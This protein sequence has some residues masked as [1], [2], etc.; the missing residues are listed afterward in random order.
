MA[1]DSSGSKTSRLRSFLGI[2]S[3]SSKSQSTSTSHVS[4]PVDEKPLERAEGSQH[5]HSSD[6]SGLVGVSGG[7]SSTTDA[8]DQTGPQS[9]VT[10]AEHETAASRNAEARL[11]EPALNKVASDDEAVRSEPDSSDLASSDRATPKGPDGK[12]IWSSAYREAVG[13]LDED[14]RKMILEGGRVDQLFKALSDSDAESAEN[15]LF[16]RGLK[17]LHKPLE[18]VKLAVDLAEPLLG[19]E[20]AVATASGAVKSFTAVRTLSLTVE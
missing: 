11:E 13:K 9:T 3:S 18:S 16:R 5:P 12:D 19:L 10:H 7:H 14:K 8:P 17:K 4:S 6:S 1:K 15:S 20:P 2:R